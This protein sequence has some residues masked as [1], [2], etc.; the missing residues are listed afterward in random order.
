MVARAAAM[1]FEVAYHRAERALGFIGTFV[2]TPVCV[3][4]LVLLANGGAL[5]HEALTAR[6][7]L[8]TGAAMLVLILAAL[9]LRLVGWIAGIG[10]S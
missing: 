10:R 8:L 1:S 6:L 4:L 2:L 7:L 3:V 9:V 5:A